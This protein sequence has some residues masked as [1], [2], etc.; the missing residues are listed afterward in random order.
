MQQMMAGYI[1]TCGEQRRGLTEVVVQRA[2]GKKQ[3]AIYYGQ[4]EDLRVGQLVLLNV[5]ATHLEL[6]TGGTDFIMALEPFCN[7]QHSPLQYGHIMKMRYTPWQMAVDTL[8]E[9]AS[10]YHGLFAQEE[11]SLAGSFVLVAEL[12][13]MLPALCIRLKE[14]MPEARIVYIMTDHTALP[15]SLSRHVHWLVSNKY[16]H[17]TVTTGQAF[18]GDGECVNTVT[19]LLAAKHVYQADWI[20]CTPGPGGVG[21]GTPYGFTGLQ[22]ADVLHHVDILGGVPF[23]L[24]RI[25][26][27]DKRERH[28]G[29]SHH[30][31]TL[32]RQFVLRPVILPI[33]LFEDE[34]D[35]SIEKQVEQSSLSQKHIV[36]RQKAG[37]VGEIDK[38]YKRHHLEK[39]SSMGRNWEEDPTPFLT[40]DTMA[41]TACWIR[42]HTE[43]N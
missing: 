43:M 19:G 22:L 8:E 18:G 36:L 4:N 34:R 26:F 11:L 40:A 30:T 31:T 29:M 32:L 5:T 15:I 21:T 20:I 10:P 27:V 33:P 28:H 24:P 17:A 13:S 16:V 42:K 9:Q 35:S 12:H 14:L 23:F 37:T 3:R 38:L 7:R 41:K 1:L 39:L 25:S 6:G 2:D